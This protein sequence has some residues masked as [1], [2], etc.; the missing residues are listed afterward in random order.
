MTLI[1]CSDNCIYQKDGYC[2][3]DRQELFKG[4]AMLSLNNDCLYY[5]QKTEEKATCSQY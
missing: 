1:R 3:N 4:A 2:T 5:T